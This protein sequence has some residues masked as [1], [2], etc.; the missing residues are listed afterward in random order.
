M[1]KRH[2]F[3]DKKLYRT[4]LCMS[5]LKV[6]VGTLNYENIASQVYFNDILK[7]T[8]SPISFLKFFSSRLLKI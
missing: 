6:N 2:M 8:E 1:S 5:H 3:D 7:M 4:S